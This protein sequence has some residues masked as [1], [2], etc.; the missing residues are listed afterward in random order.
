MRWVGFV[1][2]VMLGRE[3]VDRAL[4]LTTLHEVGAIEARSHLTTG[5]VT[6]E[7]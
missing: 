4:L 5:N 7:V 2:N 3:G 1:R 6:F